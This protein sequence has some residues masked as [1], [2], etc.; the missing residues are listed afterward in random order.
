LSQGQVVT[1]ADAT[2]IKVFRTELPFS[3]Q[4]RGKAQFIPGW[5]DQYVHDDAV[6]NGTSA[7]ACR[8]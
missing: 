6:W 8:E 5:L 7:I 1:F 3:G 2:I 4:D